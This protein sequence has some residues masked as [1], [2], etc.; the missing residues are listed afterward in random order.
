M[1]LLLLLVVAFVLLAHTVTAADGVTVAQVGGDNGAVSVEAFSQPQNSLVN[2]SNGDVTFN[3][4]PLMDGVVVA[5]VLACAYGGLFVLIASIVAQLYRMLRA[6]G[7]GGYCGDDGG[8][9]PPGM[10]GKATCPDCSSE[11][12]STGNGKN[13]IIC[14]D[15]GLRVEW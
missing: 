9:A 12:L 14:L 4:A 13:E 1:K 5:V 11:N 2:Y 10:V 6:G 8:G 7:G 15:C 3:T